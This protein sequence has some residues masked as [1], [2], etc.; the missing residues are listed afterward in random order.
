M[1]VGS[2]QSEKAIA[3]DLTLQPPPPCIANFLCPD[4]CCDIC[5]VY[6][7]GQLTQR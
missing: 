2:M 4:A 7:N 5:A 1:H 3:A 6:R